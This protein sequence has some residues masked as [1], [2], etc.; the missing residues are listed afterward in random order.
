MEAYKDVV[1]RHPVWLDM[2]FPVSGVALRAKGVGGVMRYL[3]ATDMPENW[4]VDLTED[5]FAD[6]MANGIDVLATYEKTTSEFLGGFSAGQRAARNILRDGGKWYHGKKCIT[7]DQHFTPS[8]RD[9]AVAYALGWL[10]II[11]ANE[12]VGYGFAEAVD[13]FIGCGIGTNWQC[14]NYRDVREGVRWY[15]RNDSVPG[16][17]T[18][19][20][21]DVTCDVND[22]LEGDDMGLTPDQIRILERLDK[23]ADKVLNN[24]NAA[25]D[26]RPLPYD[27]PDDMRGGLLTVQ[28]YCKNIAE[29]VELLIDNAGTGGVAFDYDKFIA[30]LEE[31]GLVTTKA[32]DAS[33]VAFRNN[34]IGEVKFSGKPATNPDGGQ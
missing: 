9:E 25:D 32:L 15:Q 5:E 2:A 18:V 14:G 10:D 19:T 28:G 17:T 23:V 33:L 31:K 26:Q 22:D 21:N 34:L 4:R 1:G 13:V 30:R 27:T 20:I 7:I 6:L 29:N 11:P 3:G 8:Q 12:T 16:P 24:F